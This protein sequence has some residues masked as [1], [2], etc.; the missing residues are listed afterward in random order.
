M[1]KLEL[2]QHNETH[3]IAKWLLE[4]RELGG[5]FGST[6]T[7][8]V[9][10]E[11]LTRFREDVPFEG[12]QDLRVQISAPKRA[13]NV[14][15]QIDD[16]NAYQ[17]WSA[18]FLAQD[19]LEIKAS[20]SGRGTISILTTYH[21]SP[22]PWEDNC[23][24][25][26]LNVTLRSVPEENKGEET[27][28]LRMETRF[29]DDRE[30]TM[31]IREVSL[32]TGFY[33]NQDDLKQLTSDV[34]RYA[35]Q[36]ETKTSPSDSTVVL[37]LEKVRKAGALH[38]RCVSTLG[39]GEP[40]LSHEKNTVLGFRVH[41]ML[42]AEFLQAA[43]I[44]IYDYYEPSRSC[45]TFYNLPT[46][47][48]SLQKICHK[49]VCRCAEVYKTK[50][51]SV[52]VSAANPY[53][54]YNMQ[55]EDIIKGGILQRGIPV[56]SHA[57]SPPWG[58]QCEGGSNLCMHTHWVFSRH[59]PCHTSQHEEICLP[60]HLPRLPGAARTGIV[61]HHGPDIRPVENQIWL[62]LRPGQGDVPHA[63]ASR[64]RCH[65]GRVAGPSGGIF[66]IY[67]HPRLRVLSLFCFQEGVTRQLWA[68]GFNPK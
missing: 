56:W 42:Q 51:E 18:K 31:T 40:K 14:N 39:A 66:R 22:V 16:N 41:R 60:H 10:L 8:V 49:D 24:L 15:W 38:Q 33:T 34:K 54:Y 65:Q 21:K 9:A 32:L 7:T 23:K 2:G 47:Q 30:A 53:V 35:F 25:Y 58:S 68:T 3:P 50:L 37:Y 59:R 52:E 12:V 11:A 20:G 13:L 67:A 57:G 29:Q 27:F 55:L 63:L 4:K 62:Q 36:Y 19:D 26:Q 28:R 61:P 48:S 45:S 43:L 1:Q 46:E 64:Q 6:Q 17:Q 44:T 5:G